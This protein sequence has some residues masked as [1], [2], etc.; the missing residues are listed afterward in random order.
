MTAPYAA[1]AAA[2]RAMWDAT[3]PGLSE[4]ATVYWDHNTNDPVPARGTVPHWMHL[5]VE[6]EAEGVRA[7][8]GGRG[9]N[10]RELEG[11]V[12]VRALAS[13]GIGEA[14]LLRLLDRATGVF[15]GRRSSDGKL[16]FVGDSVLPQPGASADGVWWV[17]SAIV[18]FTYRFQG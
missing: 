4:A 16:S 17:R 5:A 11:T 9:A 2:V 3:W 15:R 1:A 6:F 14:E 7:F 8:G 12:V 10:E 18:A 13:R